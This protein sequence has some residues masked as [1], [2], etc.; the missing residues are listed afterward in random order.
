MFDYLSVLRTQLPDAEALKNWLSD[1]LVRR[2]QPDGTL[3][4]SQRGEDRAIEFYLEV[5]L[6]MTMRGRIDTIDTGFYVD[7]GC[8]DSVHLSN[9]FALYKKGWHGINVDA[10]REVIDVFRE[11]RPRDVS[12]HA[13]LSDERERLKFHEF[14]NRGLSSFDEEHVEKWEGRNR[15]VDEYWLETVTLTEVL[16]DHDAP[17]QFDLLDV[18]MEGFDLRVLRSLDFTRYRPRLILV[19]IHDTDAAAAHAHPVSSYLGE[20]GY[21]LEGYALQTGFFVDE[22]ENRK[23]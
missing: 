13:A 5:Y 21:D 1:Q 4:Y 7:V 18:D 10:N 9:T 20:R 6:G 22:A 17:E 14:A 3:S 12:V 16:D 11:R 23:G 15:I 8:Y 2:L 19:E